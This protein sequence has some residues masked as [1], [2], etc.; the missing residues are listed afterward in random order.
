MA[1]KRKRP[2][3]SIT[4]KRVKTAVKNVGSKVKKKIKKALTSKP[5]KP[6][7]LQTFKK[8]LDAKKAHEDAFLK[9]IGKK[10]K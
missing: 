9:F 8:K 7:A 5:K 4:V 2:G 10:K 3:T 6:T 1:D